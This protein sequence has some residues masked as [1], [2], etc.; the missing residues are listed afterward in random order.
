MNIELDK[1][2]SEMGRLH[3]QVLALQEALEKAKTEIAAQQ[4]PLP[5]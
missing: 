4:K 3:M 5:E 2:F 1:V